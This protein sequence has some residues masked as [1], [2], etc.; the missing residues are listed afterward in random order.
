MQQTAGPKEEVQFHPAQLKYLE[1]V[2]PSV[3]LAPETS[4]AM[5]RHYNGQQSVIKFIATRVKG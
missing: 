4:E 5:L 1:R 2:F 3:A